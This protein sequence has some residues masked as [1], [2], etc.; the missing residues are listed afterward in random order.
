MIA[1]S[2][3]KA[4][5]NARKSGSSIERIAAFCGRHR[6]LLVLAVLGA[7]TAAAAALPRLDFDNSLETMLPEGSRAQSMIRYLR[8][9]GLTEVVV[10]TLECDDEVPAASRENLLRQAAREV[11]TWIRPPMVTGL[12]TPSADGLTPGAW[13]MEDLVP[14]L[15]DAEQEARLGALADPAVLRGQLRELFRRQLSPQSM[16]ATG[17]LRRDPLG[18]Q[19]NL[20]RR[21]LGI[22]S[23]LG[24]RITYRD[25]LLLDDS[26][27]R[28][29]ILLQTATPITDGRAARELVDYLEQ[30]RL[31]L[32]PGI[33]AEYVCAHRHTVSNEM[34]LRR[35]IAVTA[36]AE[37]IIFFV[38]LLAC[39]RDPRAAV[40]IFLVPPA[41]ALLALPP[42]ALL[43]GTLSYLVIGLGTVIAGVS[44]DYGIHAFVAARHRQ[45]GAAGAAMAAGPVTSGMLTV[46]ALFLA[47]AFSSIAGYRQL[48]AFAI[49][50]L[51]FSLLLALGLLPHLL[52]KGRAIAAL[53]R[54]IGAPSAGA[55]TRDRVIVLAWLAFMLCAV[56]AFPVVGF[57]GRL[58]RLD[59]VTPEIRQAEQ[60]LDEVWR[61]GSARQAII[62]VAAPDRESALTANRE[63]YDRLRAAG[64][65]TGLVTLAT[66]WPGEA[67]R[68][69][70]A[71]RWRAFWAGPSG[72]ALLKGLVSES[73]VAGFSASAFA[74][75]I[76]LAGREP[77]TPDP[78]AHPL[79]K[80]LWARLVHER[81]GT[82][83]VFS[84][85]PDEPA[86]LLAIEDT[87][88]SLPQVRVISTPTI[89]RALSETFTTEITRITI[90]AFIAV[91]VVTTLL[92][93][94]PRLVLA[95]LIPPMTGVAGLLLIMA[96]TGLDANVIN[97]MGGIVVFGL[98][99][100][101]SY[102]MIHGMRH[103]TEGAS[104]LVVHLSALTTIVGAGVLL[105]AR[106]PALFTIGVT[107]TIG[108]VC[109][110]FSALLVIPAL[111]RIWRLH[112]A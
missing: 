78:T 83:H 57:D 43:T 17:D 55:T 7:L 91:V 64:Q 71:A 38:L 104:R 74:P 51:V 23:S 9:A 87:L 86:T 48:S 52:S 109:G 33:T 107:L 8:E 36:V 39:F 95:A 46:A 60:A 82:W 21:T 63:V 34:A 11:S 10:I 14:V 15:F 94:R 102:T 62:T 67:T 41:A 6:K 19:E 65:D 90:H 80:P 49:L 75:F 98:S 53:D 29:L 89:D 84:Y 22:T 92:V 105:L 31:G 20:L 76:E 79:V 77:S 59:G 54:Q 110:Y 112:D 37:A 103:R 32:P 106:H 27:R 61:A 12:L 88:R 47:F 26:G 56:P 2:C 93:R 35:D 45:D 50:S 58:S 30:A 69:A 42:T 68:S 81:G 70:N 85:I 97:L 100:D 99:M 4:R 3:P 40:L 25:G 73:P 1:G 5:I 72:A 28:A 66:L 108:V 18:L 101:Y 13:S 96:A 44:V 24:F 111:A 16:L